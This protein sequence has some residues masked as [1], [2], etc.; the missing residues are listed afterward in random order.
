[1]PAVISMEVPV[2]TVE[3][4]DPMTPSGADAEQVPVEDLLALDSLP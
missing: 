1:M 2:R 3:I 4:R